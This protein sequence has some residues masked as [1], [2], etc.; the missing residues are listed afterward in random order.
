MCFLRVR[1]WQNELGELQSGSG[2]CIHVVVKN[3]FIELVEAAEQ[4]WCFQENGETMVK[5]NFLGRVWK[6]V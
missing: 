5:L 3:S 1:R 2:R 6:G 4:R